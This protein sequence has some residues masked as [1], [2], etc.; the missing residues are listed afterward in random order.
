MWKVLTERVKEIKKWGKTDRK[1]G[2]ERDSE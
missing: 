1:S 2:R